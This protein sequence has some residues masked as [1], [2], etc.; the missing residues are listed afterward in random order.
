MSRSIFTRASSAR[1]RLI[2]ICSALTGLLSAPLSQPSR[3]ALTQL[4]S[5]CSAS[6]RLRAAAAM[7]CPD[8]TSRTAS[9]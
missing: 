1:S 7:L 6:P 5:V 2:S 8:S 4:N 9:C 3:C